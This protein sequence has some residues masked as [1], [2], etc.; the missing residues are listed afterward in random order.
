MKKVEKAT[1]SLP[2]NARVKILV[3]EGLKII[4]LK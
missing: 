1:W 3:E 4:S 2:K